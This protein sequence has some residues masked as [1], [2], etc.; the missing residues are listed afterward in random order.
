VSA[1]EHRQ[2]VAEICDCL[3]GKLEEAASLY[4]RL[5]KAKRAEELNP[6][7]GTSRCAFELS[8]DLAQ[9]HEELRE[10]QKALVPRSRLSTQ[11]TRA[12]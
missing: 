6:G 12:A 4:E 2:L 10:A 9:L 11:L 7:Q 5:L 8:Y 3:N 1:G